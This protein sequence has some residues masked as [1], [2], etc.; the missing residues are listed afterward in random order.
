MSLLF[1]A[2]VGHGKG[3]RWQKPALSTPTLDSF[4]SV[5]LPGH[6]ASWG[7]WCIF[8]EVTRSL[9]QA[10]R[11]TKFLSQTQWMPSEPLP[12]VPGHQARFPCS[13]EPGLLENLQIQGATD[14][15]W[16]I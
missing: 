12:P 6:C 14:P 3:P 5:H 11:L 9:G 2:N 13:Y 15:E 1:L 8:N 4:G 10:L 16:G 7:G